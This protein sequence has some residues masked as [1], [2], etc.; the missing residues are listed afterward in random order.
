MKKLKILFCL[1]CVGLFFGACEKSIQ[2]AQEDTP[3]QEY[4]EDLEIIA[5]NG[6]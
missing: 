1:L 2:E 6:D 4:L 5:N 3:K